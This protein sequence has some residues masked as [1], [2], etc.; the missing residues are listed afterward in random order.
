MVALYTLFYNFIRTR[1]KLKIT[2]A[3]QAAIAST[4]MSFGDVDAANASA[5]VRGPNKKKAG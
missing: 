2:P 3:M 5:K 1:S 4:F